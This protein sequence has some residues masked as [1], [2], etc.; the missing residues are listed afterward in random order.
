MRPTPRDPTTE[1]AD[2]TFADTSRVYLHNADFGR[3][4]FD[5]SQ[6]SGRLATADSADTGSL[7][8]T[9]GA[10]RRHLD[11]HGMAE[12]ARS[13]YREW[14]EWRRQSLPPWSAERIWLEVFSTTTRYG[15]DP[16]RLLWWALGVILLFTFIFKRLSADGFLP[17]LYLSLC[18]F[19]RLTLPRQPVGRDRLWIAAEVVIGWFVAAGFIAI[20]VRLLSP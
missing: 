6:L 14:M 7:E 17:C 12:D 15:T 4:L 8:A 13:A 3:M 1:R 20:C 5:W 2:S 9:Y 11:D 19:T 18:T 10:L 16:G